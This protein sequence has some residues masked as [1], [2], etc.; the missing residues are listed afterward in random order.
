MGGQGRSCLPACLTLAPDRVPV[1]S[2]MTSVRYGTIS[3]ISLG[4]Q[5]VKYSQIS[6]WRHTE[7]DAVSLPIL[8][9]ILH[10]QQARAVLTSYPEGGVSI[11]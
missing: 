6:S 5:H 1:R 3:L 4:P 10:R 11:R 9:S 2:R 7:Q 8:Q